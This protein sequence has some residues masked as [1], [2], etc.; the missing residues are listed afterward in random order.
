MPTRQEFLSHIWTDCINSNLREGWLD[1][2]VQG[3]TE[4][5]SAPFGDAGSIVKRMLDSGVPHKDICRFAQFV[6]YETAYGVLYSLDDP[7]VDDGDVLMLHE[8][9]LSADP[10]GREGR[11]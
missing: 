2:L 8:S 11:P 6:A 5:S 7:G 10:S 3:S 9:L 4:K 1:V